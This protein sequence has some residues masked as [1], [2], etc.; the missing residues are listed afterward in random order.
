MAACRRLS[1]RH[2]PPL[3]NPVPASR[4]QVTS[5]P[6]LDEPPSAS[7]DLLE[8]R[9]LRAPHRL[10]HL[11]DGVVERD[12]GSVRGYVGA[13]KRVLLTGMSGTGKSTVINELSARGYRLEV[14]ASTL[15]NSH[16]ESPRQAAATALQLSAWT[17]AGRTGRRW[18]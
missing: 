18:G 13:M 14:C 8:A 2:H 9:V 7:G 17:A 3:Y 10:V 1:W 15:S 16:A 12:P 4:S 6:A 5:T 11:L